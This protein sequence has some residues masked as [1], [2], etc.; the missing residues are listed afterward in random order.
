MKSCRNSKGLLLWML[1]T[2]KSHPKAWHGSDERSYCYNFKVDDIYL[3]RATIL[4][5]QTYLPSATILLAQ[6]EG[7]VGW[8]NDISKLLF[9][10]NLL[11]TSPSFSTMESFIQHLSQFRFSNSVETTRAVTKNVP[12]YFYRNRLGVNW[13]RISICPPHPTK[14]SW[15]DHIVGPI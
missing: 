13:Y 2:V 4:L 1:K 15:V 6:F 8:G 14:R 12:T 7:N 9:R 3:P 11:R 5:A 10:G